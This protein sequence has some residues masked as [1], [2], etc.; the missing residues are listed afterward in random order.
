MKAEAEIIVVSDAVE[1]TKVDL[2]GKS[3]REQAEERFSR[4]K[5]EVPRDGG[6]E[7]QSPKRKVIRVESEVTQDYVR[8]AKSAEQEEEE[9]RIFVLSAVSVPQKMMFR[10][11]K[12]C[13]EKSLSYRQLASVVMHKGEES[14]T[15]NLCKKCFNSSLKAKGEKT[16][17]ECAVET[18]CGEKGA[19]WKDLE[20][21]GKR[22][23]CT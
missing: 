14:Y 1:S 16:T 5:R 2:D 10:C 12:Q 6:E 20:N 7:I 21:D 18:G 19:P 9:E 3:H 17:D 15:T 22:T 13:S 23:I 8:E 11:D 4:R